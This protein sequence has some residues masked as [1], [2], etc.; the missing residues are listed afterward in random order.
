[1]GWVIEHKPG[2]SMNYTILRYRDV[3][4]VDL[5]AGPSPEYYLHMIHETNSFFLSAIVALS[6]F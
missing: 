6:M 4:D 5:L 1:M 2:N 3:I